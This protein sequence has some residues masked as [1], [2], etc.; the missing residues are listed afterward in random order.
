[1]AST[2]SKG[3]AQRE[4]SSGLLIKPLEKICFPT[5]HLTDGCS[6]KVLRAN[7]RLFVRNLFV[8]FAAGNTLF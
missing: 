3:K 1:M 4:M 8:E 7:V 5:H 6:K 2:F